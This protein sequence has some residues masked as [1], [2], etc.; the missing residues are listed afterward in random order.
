MREIKDLTE[1]MP[2]RVCTLSLFFVPYPLLSLL[3]PAP[4]LFS[5]SLLLCPL[6]FSLPLLYSTT[7]PFPITCVLRLRFTPLARDT[8]LGAHVQMERKQRLGARNPRVH[9][10]L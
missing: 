6:L 2:M 5:S 10:I 3:F 7:S 9:A 8:G 4:L 1:T